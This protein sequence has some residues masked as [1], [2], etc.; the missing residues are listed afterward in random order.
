MRMVAFDV[1]HSWVLDLN[2]SLNMSSKLTE[3]LQP[4][5]ESYIL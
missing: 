2:V 3:T 1:F 4:F 5:T